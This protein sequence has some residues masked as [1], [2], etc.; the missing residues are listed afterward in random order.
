LTGAAQ[1]LPHREK[2]HKAIFEN[3]SS[4]KPLFFGAHFQVLPKPLFAAAFSLKG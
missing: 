1:K 3:F 4:S 2:L